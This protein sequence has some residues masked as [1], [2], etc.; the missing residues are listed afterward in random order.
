MTLW[1]FRTR[2][3][4]YGLSK[5]RPS[6]EVMADIDLGWQ[7]DP[8]TFIGMWEKPRGFPLLDPGECIPVKLVAEG[9]WKGKGKGKSK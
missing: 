5:D 7:S 1:F 3:N 4:A 2:E 6:K 8:S 9:K